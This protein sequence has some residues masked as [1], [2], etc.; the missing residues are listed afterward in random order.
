MTVLMKPL[1][2]HRTSARFVQQIPYVSGPL[3]PGIFLKRTMLFLIY[4]LKSS[5]TML[6]IRV[7]PE[8]MR[9]VNSSRPNDSHSY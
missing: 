3:F 5:L 2:V 4:C 8:E 1:L 9:K 6:F 7:T